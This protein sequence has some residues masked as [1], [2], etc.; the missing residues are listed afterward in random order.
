M[1]LHEFDFSNKDFGDLSENEISG[2][3]NTALDD[4]EWHTPSVS[5]IKIHT[6]SRVVV[7]GY[8]N[9]SRHN[10]YHYIEHWFN[11]NGD[12]VQIWNEEYVRNRANKHNYRVIHNIVKLAEVIS[13]LGAN[14]KKVKP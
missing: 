6:Q 8:C 5:D 13:V 12:T 14:S 1:A 7:Y 10:Q 9:L 4:D 2:I 11:I 3:L